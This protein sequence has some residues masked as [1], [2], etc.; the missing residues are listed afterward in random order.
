MANC[1][2]CGATMEGLDA[3]GNMLCDNCEASMHSTGSGT[4]VPC[5]RCGMYL[6]SHEL[7]MWNSRLYCSYCIMDLKDEERMGR[8]QKKPEGAEQPPTGGLFSGLFGGK[9]SDSQPP[10]E[11]G[12]GEPQQQYPHTA[13]GI[14]ERCGREADALYM[15]QGRKLCQLCITSGGASGSTPGFFAQ[16]VSAMKRAVGIREQPKI[17][18]QQRVAVFDLRTRKM[19]EKTAGGVRGIS[20][21]AEKEEALSEDRAY[22]GPPP[23]PPPE[24]FNV[25]ERKFEDKKEGMDAEQPISEGANEEKKPSPKTKKLFFKLHPSGGSAKKK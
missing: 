7:Q 11:K 10:P 4:D 6:P 13:P 25:S 15:A 3:G 21:Q 5:Q 17:I 9:D 22:G 16:I 1:T 14:C 2:R 12:A 23:T 20:A 19:V 24:V 8:E 18:A